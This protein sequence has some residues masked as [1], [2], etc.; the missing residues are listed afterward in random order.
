[1]KPIEF[2]EQNII[3]AEN[4]EEYENLPARVDGSGIVTCLMELEKD[5]LIKVLKSRELWITRLAFNNPAQPIKLY[6]EKPEFPVDVKYFRCEPALY[7]KEDDDQG[8]MKFH[9][10]LE[11]NDLKQLYETSC[12]WLCT[13]T[14]KS[15][16][17]PI[18]LSCCG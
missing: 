1:M 10:L 17:Q 18:G 7:P 6:F 11:K 13:A 9:I 2:E 5:E 16:F 12:F 3:F 15:A 8:H 4:Q 14:F